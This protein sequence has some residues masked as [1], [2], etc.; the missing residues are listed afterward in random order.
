M[1]TLCKEEYL[2]QVKNNM[3][4]HFSRKDIHIT[5]EDVN[6]FFESGVEN[7]KTEEE[8]YN[9]LGNPK[10]F[11]HNLLY[12]RAL[13]KFKYILFVYIIS[14]SILCILFLLVYHYPTPLI[15]CIPV[16]IFPV[17]VWYSFGSYC[18]LQIRNDS[19]NHHKSYI[20]YFFIS[21]FIICAEQT[22]TV[23]LNINIRIV[24]SFMAKTYFLSSFFHN[25][26]SSRFTNHNL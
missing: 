17:F 13:D 4:L 23:L 11:V 20:I 26:I 16:I 24:S 9:E 3:L 8:L 15:L 25:N 10:D 14:F 5:L 19:L 18:L 21:L 6:S 22:F 1:S 2:E 7:G 12:D